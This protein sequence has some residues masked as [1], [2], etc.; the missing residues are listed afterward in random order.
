VVG[1]VNLGVLVGGAVDLLVRTAVRASLRKK[2]K[3]FV[4][5]IFVV[6][7]PEKA[8]LPSR[9]LSSTYIT[10]EDSQTHQIA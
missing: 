3:G 8:Q 1:L 9:S 10:V 5:R 2:K 7:I 4:C 6:F